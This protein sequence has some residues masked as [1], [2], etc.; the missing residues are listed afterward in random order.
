MTDRSGCASA[1]HS[2]RVQRLR[3]SFLPS[4]SPLALRPPTPPGAAPSPPLPGPW[5]RSPLAPRRAPH[6]GAHGRERAH[7][8]AGVRPAPEPHGLR[9]QNR[10]ALSLQ[11]H[12]QWRHLLRRH[13]GQSPRPGPHPLQKVRR[14]AP[15]RQGRGVSE[16]LSGMMKECRITGLPWISQ[17]I[18]SRQTGEK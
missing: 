5:P 18:V 1:P 12:L 6:P 10:K 16:L 8:H 9:H 4:C 17:K 7:K 14:V 2:V 11:Q 15:A 3:C 13:P